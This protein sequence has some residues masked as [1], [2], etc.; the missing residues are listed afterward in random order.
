MDIISLLQ[1]VDLISSRGEGR[2]LVQQG[3]I[4]IN[5]QRIE[6]ID[7]NITSDDFDENSL[8]IRKGKKIYH[9]VNLV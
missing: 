1:K 9:R 5:E 7:L 2:R 4:Y 8:M 6:D 3:G